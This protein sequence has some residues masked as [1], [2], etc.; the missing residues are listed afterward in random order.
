MSKSGV[1]CCEMLLNSFRAAE[2]AAKE[3][4][5]AGQKKRIK[6]GTEEYGRPEW[7]A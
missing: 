7:K 3:A 6:K 5:K 1:R 2:T 4:E